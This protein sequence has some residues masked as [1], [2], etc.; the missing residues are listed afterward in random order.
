LIFPKHG[1]MIQHSIAPTECGGNSMN[2]LSYAHPQLFKVF[3]QLI[4]V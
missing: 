3:K 2:V 1:S 4:Y